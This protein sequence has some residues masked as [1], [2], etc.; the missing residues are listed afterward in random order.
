MEERT[1]D[2][3]IETE[4]KTKDYTN[5]WK[6]SFIDIGSDI[7]GN[8]ASWLS[9][10]QS[11]GDSLKNIWGNTA[12]SPYPSIAMDVIVGGVSS[13]MKKVQFK[14]KTFVHPKESF[15]YMCIV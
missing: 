3:V 9:G 6:D 15:A 5:I 13:T 7:K 11:F 10:H 12:L 2:F 8:L 1:G 14:C 4:K